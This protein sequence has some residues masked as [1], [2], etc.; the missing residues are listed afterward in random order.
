LTLP[1]SHDYGLFQQ[2]PKTPG[3]R[4]IKDAS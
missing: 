4:L 2:A 1:I 3:E